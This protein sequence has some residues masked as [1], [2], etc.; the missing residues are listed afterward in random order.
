MIASKENAE[1]KGRKS[2]GGDQTDRLWAQERVVPTVADNKDELRNRELDED[3]SKD[4]KQPRAPQKSLRLIK[5]KL[6]QRCREE[7]QRDNE[8]FSRFR[9]LPTENKE[10]QAGNES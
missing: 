7:E 5:P 1:G 3:D 6:S 8:V 9:L 2:I 10:G 4:E